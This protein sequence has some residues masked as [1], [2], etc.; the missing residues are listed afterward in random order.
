MDLHRFAGE[1]D[2]AGV[3]GFE[4][5][6]DAGEVG[7]TGAD[8]TRKAQNL[9]GADLEV[10]VLDSG[11]C[12]WGGGLRA[13]SGRGDVAAGKT[14]ER[15]RPTMSLMRSLRVTDCMGCVPSELAVAEGGDAVGDEGEFLQAVGD[16]DDADVAVAEFT[17]DVEQV[18]TVGV[19][20]EAV[21][22]SM[23]RMR[24]SAPRARAIS[25]SCCWGIERRRTSQSGGSSLRCGREVRGHAAAGGPT[26]GTE[27]PP[28]LFREGEVFSD[29][30]SGKRAGC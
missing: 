26:D 9:S 7:A 19:S 2:V 18:L 13:V 29:G 28:L 11:R 14:A 8:E 21:G 15:S 16:V 25:T 6:E 17:D 12:W 23:M 24:A 20:K 30:G 5:E 10:D 27:D 4:T 1:E 3:T 22:S